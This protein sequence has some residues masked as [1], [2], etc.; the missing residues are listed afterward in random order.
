[1]A[2]RIVN[3]LALN[4]LS[5]ADIYDP[6]GLTAEELRDDLFLSIPGDNEML[7]EIEDPS[8]FLKGTIDVATKEIQKTVSFQ[9]LSTNESNGQY[10]LD[11]KK[12]IDVDSLITQRA[13]MIE[14]DKLDRYYFDILKKAISILGK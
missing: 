10:Y 6:V 9:Y 1:M 5:T 12:D 3:A 13:E 7:I 14:E 8:D 11:L 4:R 2:L